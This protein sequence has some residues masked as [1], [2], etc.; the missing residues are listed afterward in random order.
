VLRIELHPSGS[1]A[2]DERSSL[3]AYYQPWSTSQKLF[4]KLGGFG[5]M[6]PYARPQFP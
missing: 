3:A 4:I 1:L 2:L 6:N 5:G